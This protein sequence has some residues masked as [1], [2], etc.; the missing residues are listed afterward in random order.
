MTIFD[1][2]T[3]FI[4]ENGLIFFF[5]DAYNWKPFFLE[6]AVHSFDFPIFPNDAFLFYSFFSFFKNGLCCCFV[7]RR[8]TAEQ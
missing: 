7:I 8:P 3:M 5:K 2:L 6:S 4:E 1:V